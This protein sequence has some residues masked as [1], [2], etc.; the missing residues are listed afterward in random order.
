MWTVKIKYRDLTQLIQRDLTEKDA[1]G[2][3]H[4]ACHD[5]K[6]L[7]VKITPPK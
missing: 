1:F 5:P 3:V 7:F 4:D 6:V 2:L